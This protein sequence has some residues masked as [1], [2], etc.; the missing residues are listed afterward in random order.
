MPKNRFKIHAQY[1]PN[2]DLR[3]NLNKGK[4]QRRYKLKIKTSPGMLSRLIFV[5]IKGGK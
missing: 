1:K 2:I 5:K 4:I 3:D